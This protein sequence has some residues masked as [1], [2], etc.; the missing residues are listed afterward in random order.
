MRTVNEAD[1]GGQGALPYRNAALKATKQVVSSAKS[2][3]YGLH[4]WNQDTSDTYLQFYDALTAGVTVGTT[5]PTLTLVVPASSGI[6]KDTTIP[7]EF[8]TGIVVAATTTVGGS[9]NPT[10]G[11]LINLFYKA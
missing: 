6:D 1:S 10:N 8:N 7:W 4:V 3:V 5:T 2:R 9:T 11:L